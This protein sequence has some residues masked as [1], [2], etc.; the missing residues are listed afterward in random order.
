MVHSALFYNLE[1]YFYSSSAIWM[2]KNIHVV[3]YHRWQRIKCLVGSTWDNAPDFFSKFS[4]LVLDA[5]IWLRRITQYH[6]KSKKKL[7]FVRPN[8]RE[9]LCRYFENCIIASN[10]IWS[11]F[12]LWSNWL[13][14]QK[15]PI[16]NFHEFSMDSFYLR[17]SSMI[18]HKIFFKKKI[19]AMCNLRN[20]TN[21]CTMYINNFDSCWSTYN[22][23]HG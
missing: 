7:N 12:T 8:S 19:Y 22:L 20:C 18:S 2:Q 14:L 9:K 6:G 1:A 13:H 4:C 5:K 16:A 23:H 10:C 17:E 15:Y 11:K 3:I 21:S